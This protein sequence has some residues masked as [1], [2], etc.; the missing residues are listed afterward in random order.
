MSTGRR[1]LLVVLTV[2]GLLFAG[3]MT[4]IVISM[5][6]W[7]G[8]AK[9][10]APVLCDPARPDPVVVRDTYSY[11]PG[12]TSMTFTLYCVGP[13][14]DYDEIGVFRPFLVLTAAHTTLIALAVV[15]FVIWARLRR[16]GRR[17]QAG[18][19]GQDP[20]AASISR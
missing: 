18:L 15:L 12:E 20:S 13:R 10:T 1:G 11:R 9:L 6:I 4:T 17:R 19:P 2:G 8:E 14:G 3:V 5:A 7:P 16:R